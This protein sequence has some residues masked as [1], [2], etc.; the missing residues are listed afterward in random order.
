M[1][2]GF[3]YLPAPIPA[4][5]KMAVTV[6]EPPLFWRSQLQQAGFDPTAYPCP[7]AQR[8]LGRSL[9]MAFN[10]YDDDPEAMALIGQHLIAAADVIRSTG[11]KI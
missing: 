4:L 6:D 10:W 5:P 3:T 11:R 9:E 7:A 8:R 2:S 1:V